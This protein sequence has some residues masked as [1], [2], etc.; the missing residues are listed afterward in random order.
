MS[1]FGFRTLTSLPLDIQKIEADLQIKRLGRRIHYFAQLD[2][3]NS[4]ARRLAEKGSLEGEIV[5]AETQSQGRG[6]LSRVWVSPSHINLYLSFILRPHLPPIHAPQITLMAAVAL[7]DTIAS[8]TSIP[9]A[10]KW[11]NDILL[12]G[13]KL[14]GILCE[15]SCA[16]DRI[17]F[18]I[19]GIGI[20]LNYPNELMPESI[21]NRATS[22]L[23]VNREFINRETFASRL[24]QDLD[25]CY[26]EL[27]ELGFSAI[28]SRWEGRFGW[29]GKKVKVEVF[30]Q[31][32]V[33]TAAG[34]DRDGALIVLDER[35]VPHR[36]IAGD[37][38]G[39]AGC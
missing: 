24:I 14:A 32:V 25:R 26:G 8:F 1:N 19:L 39:L 3:T 20:N 15:S 27:E 17:E 5:I 7:A 2:S 18:V 29:R 9:P 13:K 10:I 38:T 33:G 4:H 36:V 21:R 28:A 34:I 22:L 16:S 11:P 30:D 37:V 6:R 35:G 31:V 12:G 23:V